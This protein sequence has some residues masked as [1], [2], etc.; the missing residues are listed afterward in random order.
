MANSTDKRNPP[1]GALAALASF[2]GKS[3]ASAMNKPV[4]LSE[5]DTVWFVD[6]GVLD[7]A[8]AEYGEAGIE[9]SFKHLFQVRSGGLVFGL[10]ME[11]GLKLV[12][13]GL[14]GTRLR[15]LGTSSLLD[16]TAEAG[17]GAELTA[18][19]V[20]L[21]DRWIDDFAA[22]VASD[23]TPRPRPAAK[24]NADGNAKPPA[25]GVLFAEQGVVWLSGGDWTLPSCNSKTLCPADPN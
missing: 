12:A 1:A 15:K 5:A 7:V 17:G 6:S 23:F 24:L 9:S 20:T 13:K 21:A 25:P 19:L 18:E 8:V 14:P 10:D 22:A 3:C 4:D 2:A 11:S 16:A